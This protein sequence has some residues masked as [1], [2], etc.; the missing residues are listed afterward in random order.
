M[1]L[2]C[3][4]AKARDSGRGLC[5]QGVPEAFFFFF[6][7]A[8]FNIYMVVRPLAYFIINSIPHTGKDDRFC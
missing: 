4:D 3:D 8:L 5:D 2:V 7:N 1:F 6:L